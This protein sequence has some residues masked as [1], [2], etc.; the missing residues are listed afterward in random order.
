MELAFSTGGT[1]NGGGEFLPEFNRCRCFPLYSGAADFFDSSEMGGGLSLGCSNFRPGEIVM[2]SLVMLA[3]LHRWVLVARAGWRRYKTHPNRVWY[4]DFALRVLAFDSLVSV[5]VLI[6]TSGMKLA[7]YTLGT[8]AGVTVYFFVGVTCYQLTVKVFSRREFEVTT[9]FLPRVER[10]QLL[11]LYGR[12]Q[13]ASWILHLVGAGIPTVVT[14]TLD[15]TLGPIA[16]HEFAYILVRN[17]AVLLWCL[18]SYVE[19]RIVFHKF[20]ELVQSLVNTE[21]RAALERMRLGNQRLNHVFVFMVLLFG[22]FSI[23]HMWGYQTYAYG[24]L[25]VVTSLQNPAMLFSQGRLAT[26]NSADEGAGGGGRTGGPMTATNSKNEA[27]VSPMVSSTATAVVNA[28]P[29]AIR[30]LE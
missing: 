7:G 9:S 25:L 8:H 16:N 27:V 6:T 20:N 5:P 26:S 19:A 10:E 22:S 2:W 17:I 14:L 13:I 15:K 12:M 29:A 21:A 3:L 23:P 4:K 24:I 30:D 11:R 1:C 18:T 28:P